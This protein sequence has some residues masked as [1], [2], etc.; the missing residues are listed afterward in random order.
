MQLIRDEILNIKD[1]CGNKYND[2]I[3]DYLDILERHI[4]KNGIPGEKVIRK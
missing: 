4:K 1:K 2:A 3:K